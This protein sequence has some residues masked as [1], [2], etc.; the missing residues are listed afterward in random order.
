MLLMTTVMTMML[1]LMLLLLL[2]MLMKTPILLLL[3]LRQSS[4][5][6]INVGQEC[7]ETVL[8]ILVDRGGSTSIITAAELLTFS[9]S[10]LSELLL[11]VI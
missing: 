8:P 11:Y 5:A 3:L 7:S 2:V 1:L 6:D 10:H 9:H 4:K